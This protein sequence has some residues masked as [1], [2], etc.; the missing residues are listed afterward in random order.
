M[1]GKINPKDIIDLICNLQWSNYLTKGFKGKGYL[2]KLHL[3]WFDAEFC[4]EYLNYFY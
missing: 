3:F 1:D 2:E 4:F